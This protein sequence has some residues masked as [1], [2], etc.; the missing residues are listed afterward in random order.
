MWSTALRTARRSR[1]LSVRP[2][3]THTDEATLLSTA[4]RQDMRRNDGCLT[5]RRVSSDDH[6]T[7]IAFVDDVVV[8]VVVQDCCCLSAW[9]RGWRCW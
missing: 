2:C 9:K 8:A 1:P 6:A 5:A 4:H 7:V 3:P